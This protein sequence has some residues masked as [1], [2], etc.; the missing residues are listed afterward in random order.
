MSLQKISESPNAKIYETASFKDGLYFLEKNKLKDK[1]KMAL[2]D[3]DNT[4]LSYR[5]T[6]GTDQWF[7]FDFNDFIKQGLS[8]IQA[9]ENTL[10][11]YLDLVNKIHPDDIYAIEEDTPAAI[12][13]LQELGIDTLLL[14]S[15][16]SYLL[17]QTIEQLKRFQIDFNLGRFKNRVEDLPQGKE[18]ILHHG[19]ILAGG[20]HKGACLFSIL[21]TSE[22]LPE[23]IVMWDD[24]LSN[25][26]KVRAS[27]EE[28]NAKSGRPPIQFVGLRYSKLDHI[29]K[30]VKAE[31]IDLQKRYHQ[32]ILSNEHA[33][34]ILKAETKKDRTPYVDVDYRPQEQC[35]ILSL[36][37]Y[38]VYKLLQNIEPSIIK[39]QMIGDVKEFYGKKKLAWQFKLPIETFK[40]LFHQLSSHGL[41]ANDQYDVLYPIFSEAAN[42]ITFAYSSQ[43]KLAKQIGVT[44]IP[45]SQDVSNSRSLH[46]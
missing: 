45:S 15:R 4:I 6:L 25:L 35:V 23:Y 2:F 12:R 14:T 36:S 28:Y 43:S 41:I 40:P 32:R 17:S 5:H 18:S 11:L 38:R 19:M 24:K 3:L 29:V 20:E 33:M 13:K 21:N 31:V 10:S 7:D 34:A 16:G 8:T 37:K 46:S 44:H 30:E 22:E 1:R 39:Y 27:I 9:K 42:I 26:E